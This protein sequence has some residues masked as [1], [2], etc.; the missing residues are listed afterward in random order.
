MHSVVIEH[1]RN[2]LQK[3][4]YTSR[5]FELKQFPKKDLKGKLL[6]VGCG[7]LLTYFP[8]KL[9]VYGVDIVPEMIRLFH[10]RYSNAYCIVADVRALPFRARCFDVV[11][12]AALLHHLIG[13]NPRECRHNVKAA[14]K[15]VN[16]VLKKSG[17]V[18]ITELLAR[19]YLFQLVIFYISLFCSKFNIEINSLEIRS[20]V[21]TYF[22]T[23]REFKQLCWANLFEIKELKSQSWRLAKKIKLGREVDFLLSK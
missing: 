14:I 4:Q 23:E 9:E 21:I 10:K 16:H 22:L 1:F 18:L 15:E 5:C 19:N 11:V 20:K 8:E 6:E 3:G 13:I 12:A 17:I 2:R 7:T